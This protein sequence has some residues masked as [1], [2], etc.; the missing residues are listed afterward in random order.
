MKTFTIFTVWLFILF[1]FF[2]TKAISQKLPAFNQSVDDYI[3]IN[4]AWLPTNYILNCKDFYG[5]SFRISHESLRF[6]DDL[7]YT[8]THS[9]GITYIPNIDKHDSNLPK[10]FRVFGGA[11]IIADKIEP[12]NFYGLYGKFG[13]LFSSDDQRDPSGFSLGFS[14][15]G[16]GI[17]ISTS[18]DQ[19]LEQGDILANR[20][21]QQWYFDLGFGGYYFKKKGNQYLIY[22]GISVPSIFALDYTAKEAGESFKKNKEFHIYG[23]LG[24][25]KYLNGKENQALEFII[26]PRVVSDSPLKFTKTSP[27]NLDLTTRYYFPYTFWTGIG[28]DFSKNEYSPFEGIDFEFGINILKN[29]MPLSVRAGLPINNDINGFSY[30]LALSFFVN[31]SKRE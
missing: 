6:G 21:L 5:W 23:I 28:L 3:A 27:L 7:G 19:F 17:E 9:A 1:L 11:N 18:E 13:V 16:S 4:P 14:F 31:K 30:Q 26:N 20:N 29:R 10:T 15:G 25:K 12:T 24:F 2:N 8:S 22:S